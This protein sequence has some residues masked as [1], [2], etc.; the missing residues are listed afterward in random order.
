[1]K[2]DYNFDEHIQLLNYQQ[3]LKKQNKLLITHDPETYSKLLHYSVLISD[4]LHW[5]EKN[6]YLQLIRDFLN[7]K[8]DG[9]E[10][11]EKFSTMFKVIEKRSRLLFQNYDELKLLKPS[12]RS[13]GF[14]RLISEIYLCCEEFYEDYDV[15]EGED[16]ALKTEKQLRDAVTSLFPEIQKYF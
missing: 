16:P 4:Y 9:K 6:D 5:S 8:I 15:S 11:D 7:S 10:F 14:G 2:Y 3:E 13:L 1:M 12:S